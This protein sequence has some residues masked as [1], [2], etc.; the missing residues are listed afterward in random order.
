MN[1]VVNY[2]LTIMSYFELL[3]KA[4]TANFMHLLF[5]F[6][7]I[8]LKISKCMDREEI[9][10]YIIMDSTDREGKESNSNSS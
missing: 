7:H 4:A 1:E 10:K 9:E 8:K 6:F 3:T 2:Y 5:L